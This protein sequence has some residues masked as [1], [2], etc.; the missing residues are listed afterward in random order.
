[1]AQSWNLQQ[2]VKKTDISY[3]K[4]TLVAMK[5]KGRDNKGWNRRGEMF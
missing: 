3:L 5:G 1:M 4:N 2:F